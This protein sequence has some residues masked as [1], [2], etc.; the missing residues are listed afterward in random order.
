MQRSK[1]TTTLI[2]EV[3]LLAYKNG[4]FPMAD[5][6]SG[7]VQWHR[8]DP[9]AVIPLTSVKI[10]RSLKQLLRKQVFTVSVDTAFETVVQHCAN[11]EETW[12]NA[13]IIDAYSELYSLGYAHSVEVWSN[14]TLVGGLYGVAIKGAFFGESMFSLQSNASKVAFAYLVQHL[15][16]RGY[17]LLDSQYIND[18]TEQL[19]AIEVS[20]EVYQHALRSAMTK[21]VHFE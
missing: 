19:G 8:P 16:S 20:D 6:Y 1:G 14:D 9:R 3:I 2:P 7:K 15:L 11:R 5:P 12:I 10:P 13:E 4:F 18:F 17:V 21:D